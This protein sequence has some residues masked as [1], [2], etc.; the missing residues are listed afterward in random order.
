MPTDF[1]VAENDGKK[2]TLTWSPPASDGASSIDDYVISY[3]SKF[4]PKSIV[5]GDGVSAV[6]GFTAT[7]PTP[8]LTFTFRVHAANGVGPGAAASIDATIPHEGSPSSLTA[9]FVTVNDD[10]STATISRFMI[11]PRGWWSRDHLRYTA[12]VTCVAVA[13]QTFRWLRVQETPSVGESSESFSRR[14]PNR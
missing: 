4:H 5:V 11:P 13:T 12:A 9:L 6:T 14:D 7:N 3:T 8:G 2:L 10:V 1:V